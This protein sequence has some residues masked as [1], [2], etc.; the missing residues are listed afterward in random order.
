MKGPLDARRIE[1]QHDVGIGGQAAAQGHVDDGAA[2]GVPAGGFDVDAG[3]DG[4][5]ETGIGGDQ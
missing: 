2:I 4:A 3:R 1:R 5:R